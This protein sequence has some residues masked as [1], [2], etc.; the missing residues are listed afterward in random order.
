MNARQSHDERSNE[1]VSPKRQKSLYEK[2]PTQTNAF[3]P[4]DV[5]TLNNLGVDCFEHGGIPDASK[6]FQNA[7]SIFAPALP[8]SLCQEAL[9]PFPP[10]TPARMQRQVSIDPADVSVSGDDSQE[11]SEYP[12]RSPVAG[13]LSPPAC[14]S[15]A[16][17]PRPDYDEGM[18]SYNRPLRIDSNLRE[19]SHFDY[20]RTVPVLLF[21]IG[22][23]RVL[24]GD[25]TMAASYFLY[26]LDI[27]NQRACTDSMFYPQV[28]SQQRQ[29]Q[30]ETSNGPILDAIPIL[31][32]LGHIYYRA[33]NYK[34]AMT[35]YYDALDI[36]QKPKHSNL[37]AMAST[38]NCLGV[39]FFHMSGSSDENA[40][41]ALEMFTTSLEIRKNLINSS[42]PNTNTDVNTKS[43]DER[44]EIATTMNNVGRVHYMLGDHTAALTTYIEA[45]T[46]RKDLLPANHLDLA[47]SAYNLGQTHHQLGNLDEAMKLYVEFY[48]IVSNYLGSSHRDVAIILKC[49]AQ[50]HHDKSE[51][52]EAAGLYYESLQTTKAA[53][54]ELH[55]E[56]ASTLNKIG[57]MYYENSDFER[58]IK[59]YEEGLIVEQAVL[60]SNHQNIVVTLTNI[61][62]SHKHKGNH[63]AAL[64]R[65][66]EAYNLQR[67]VLG[68]S[69]PKVAVTLSNV[70]QVSCRL[71]HFTKALDAYQEVLQIRRDA[72]G[73]NHV[74]VAATLNSIGL[75]LFRQGYHKLAI[76]SFEESLRVR[77][78]CL[79]DQHRDVAVVLYN[80]ATTYLEEG[81]DDKAMAC[82]AET[83]RVERSALGNDHRD[84]VVT[85]QHIGQ[86]YQQRGEL[87]VSLGYF[88]EVLRIE[89]LHHGNNSV[90]VPQ[91][92]NKMG[93]IYLQKADVPNMMECFAEATRIFEA[94]SSSPSE[95]VSDNDEDV[96]EELKITGYNFYSISIF[97]PECAAAA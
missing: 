68:S 46:L 10:P 50:V 73:D 19:G 78:L 89:R 18:N 35:M 3:H 22:Q 93:N 27:I 21:N 6:C 94:L 1:Q 40:S 90:I 48:D 55:P 95:T 80:I 92:L 28:Q 62:Q 69:N 83:L 63:A 60:Q 32:N 54:G 72:H 39:I 41:K 79:G 49:M 4:S 96:S 70:A 5:A 53:L 91:I 14:P 66:M 45:Y 76:E 13:P 87:D 51:Y 97:H 36:A 81:D 16:A 29:P 12:Q 31:H 33:Q 52:K 58:A 75:V 77:R 82:Y 34:L 84:L 24:A 42:L 74:D 71:G 59:A 44:R 64:E 38:L 25:D 8:Q 30:H 15:V 23:L 86:V 47:A 88:T 67:M 43:Q 11:E 57:N 26:A 7:M 85:L 9:K 20:Q 2:A 56:V 65:Y 37:S 61:A 17:A